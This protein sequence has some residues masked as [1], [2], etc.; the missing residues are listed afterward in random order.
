MAKGYR[1]QMRTFAQQ[2]ILDVW[3][4]RLDFQ[5]FVDLAQNETQR[6]RR[7]KALED[8]KRNLLLMFWRQ[9]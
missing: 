3:Y 4:S 7:Q 5:H 6:T 2:S 8:A 1:E 9:N